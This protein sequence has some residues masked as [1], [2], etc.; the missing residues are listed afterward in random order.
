VSASWVLADATSPEV[1]AWPA[2]LGLTVAVLVVIALACWGMWAGWRGR[3]A[4]QGDL[5]EPPAEPVSFDPTLVTGVQGRYLA[6][7]TAGDWLDR[8]TAHGLGAV[9]NAWLSVGE[10]GVLIEREGARDLFIPASDLV[11]VRADRGI[12][13]S[14]FEPGGVVVITW[15]L[16][17]RQL[18]SGLRARH[19]ED[20]VA[21]VRAVRALLDGASPLAADGGAA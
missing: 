11:D 7:T 9:G 8:I 17:D 5:P 16:G 2:R 14:V 18:D 13:G 15:Q 19:V 4:R 1:T 6:S 3:A 21:V 12:A 10:A 20:H